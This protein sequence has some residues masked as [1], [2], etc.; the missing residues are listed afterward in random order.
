MM[1]GTEDPKHIE[2]A[3]KNAAC[4]EYVGHNGENKL[5]HRVLACSQH[6]R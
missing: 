5:V 4:I 2:Q 6:L 3:E 1:Y